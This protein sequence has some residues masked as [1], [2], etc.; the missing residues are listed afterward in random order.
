MAEFES[1]SCNQ[2][3]LTYSK[4]ESNQGSNEAK[5][6]GLSSNKRNDTLSV[7]TPRFKHQIGDK[8]ER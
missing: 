4:Q 8:M 6:L 1:E 2:I 5:I 7:V 3:G